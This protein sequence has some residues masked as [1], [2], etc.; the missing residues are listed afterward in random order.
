MHRDGG[1]VTWAGT[2]TTAQ[3]TLTRSNATT[4]CIITGRTP[5]ERTMPPWQRAGPAS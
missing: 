5:L 1:T 4:L 2:C 3:G